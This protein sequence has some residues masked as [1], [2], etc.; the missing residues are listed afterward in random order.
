VYQLASARRLVFV[1]ARDLLFRVAVQ[2]TDEMA[3]ACYSDSRVYWFAVLG[4]YSR[5]GV[6]RSQRIFAIPS[7]V[8]AY[9]VK[10]L[11]I[12]FA[13]SSGG[14]A[15]EPC[16]VPVEVAAVRIQERQLIYCAT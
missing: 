16:S 14:P 1:A 4:D 2:P 12:D 11:S 7:L 8:L 6:S 3:R 13:A 9:G 15:H 10:P 5:P